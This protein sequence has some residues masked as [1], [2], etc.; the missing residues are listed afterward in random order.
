[1]Y[2]MT[3]TRE[4]RTGQ[5][6]NPDMAASPAAILISPVFCLAAC[7]WGGEPRLPPSLP[8]MTLARRET[9]RLVLRSE[10][11][12]RRAAGPETIS[13]ESR[14]LRCDRTACHCRESPYDRRRSQIARREKGFG[15]ASWE[16]GAH[17]NGAAERQRSWRE[18][19]AGF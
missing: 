9:C 12:F 13:A 4:R 19:S 14:I 15:L 10:A 5:A 17:S 11:L 3:T 7:S 1:M 6:V 18:R 2:L 8:I 16:D